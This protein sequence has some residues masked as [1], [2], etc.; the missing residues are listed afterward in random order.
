M[1]WY[2]LSDTQE[3]VPVQDD[4]L[5]GLVQ[6]GVVRPSTMIWHEGM[7][8][9]IACSEAKP[10]LFV[11]RHVVPVIGA[12][13]TARQT[14]ASSV[15]TQ[16]GNQMGDGQLVREAAS[17]FATASIW[18]KLLGIL[19]LLTGVAHILMALF[20]IVTGAS[21]TGAL[22]P[23]ILVGL[24]TAGIGAIVMWMGMLLFQSA[25]KAHVAVLSGRKEPLLSALAQNARFF[26][27]WGVTVALA[28]ILYSLMFILAFSGIMGGALMNMFNP[29]NSFEQVEKMEDEGDAATSIDAGNTGDGDDGDESVENSPEED[30]GPSETDN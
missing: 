21:M 26:K 2:F 1:Q 10:E 16:M 12:A 29:A 3:Q 8:E 22:I 17:T 4:H 15:G 24:I 13:A 18:M 25:N 14:S 20:L 11:Q 23:A 7:D 5:A 6:T 30:E 19:F 27:I 28:I 9:W